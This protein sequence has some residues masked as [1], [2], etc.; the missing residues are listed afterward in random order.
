MN[1]GCRWS[2]WTPP[3]GTGNGAR[4]AA[5]TRTSATR[6][7]PIFSLPSSTSPA[8]VSRRV[9]I[10]AQM[11]SLSIAGAAEPIAFPAPLYSELLA[12]ASRRHPRKTFGYLLSS[13]S[14][15]RPTDFILFEENARNSDAWQAEFHS[16]GRYFIEHADAGFVATPEESWQ[17]QKVIWARGLY[18]V[19]VLHSHQRHPANF[20]L[21][22]WDM[23]CQRFQGLWHL[24][25]SMRNPALPQVRAYAVHAAG[26][27]EL[28]L[29]V[30]PGPEDRA[31]DDAARHAVPRHVV[32]RRDVAIDRVRALSRLDATGRPDLARAREI[33]A[34]VETLRR[35]GRA[36]V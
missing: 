15:N 29:H 7:P 17:A 22:D 26:V 27:R 2:T 10:D 3:G 36:H 24:I 1:S 16:Y 11:T 33:V 35:I 20:S 23:H 18:E 32:S 34:A 13:S 4:L 5:R 12:E 8:D 28:A 31:R 30:T 9:A 6:N 21:I 19:A 14:A 25:I